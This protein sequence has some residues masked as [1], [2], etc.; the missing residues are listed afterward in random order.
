MGKNKEKKED[1]QEIQ[2]DE[3]EE[4]TRELPEVEVGDFVKVKQSFDES[5]V[6]AVLEMD[7]VEDHYWDNIK[8]GLM[9]VACL[10]AMVAQFYPM[11]FPESR[12]LLGVCCVAYFTASTILQMIV[13]YI[14]K[15]C[16][17]TTLPIPSSSSS[18]DKDKDEDC[19]INKNRAGGIYGLRIST[20][21]PRFSYDFT[22]IVQ[23]NI[24][25]DTT[26]PPPTLGDMCSMRFKIHDYL[27][28]DGKFDDERFE[29]NVQ[30]VIK[31]FENKDFYKDK[32][33]VQSRKE[34]TS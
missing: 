33:W 1:E 8:L 2:E 9:V 7:Y 14:E 28:E 31:D 24:K 26:P 18:S 5:V 19:K 17:M 27:T 6:K 20:T 16:I 22:V 34:K 3:F 12:P 30:S 10:F 23:E 15:D 32:L 29:R 21:F 4:E 11:P 25:E 13:T